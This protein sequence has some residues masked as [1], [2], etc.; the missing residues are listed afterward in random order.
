RGALVG[1]DAVTKSVIKLRKAFGD[2]AKEPSII[3]TIPKRGYRLVA[4]VRYLDADDDRR[5]TVPGL[6]EAESAPAE[7][8]GISLLSTQAPA[9]PRWRRA[10][11]AK[12]LLIMAALTVLAGFG[13]TLFLVWSTATL[14]APP[15]PVATAGRAPSIVVLPF[16]NLSDDPQFEAFADGISEDLITDLSG[17]PALLVIASNTSFTFKGK[18]IPA[19]E[20]A[21]DLNVDF[22]LEGNIRRQAGTVRLNAR[23]VDARNGLQRW[24]KRY[25]RQIADV[26][27]VQDELTRNIVDALAIKLSR[28]E[29]ERL[30]RRTTN[31]LAAYDAFQEGQRLAKIST[32]DSNREAQAMYRQAIELDPGYG[33]AYGALAYTLAFRYRRGWA[34][35]PQLTLERALEVARKAVDLD[36]SIPQTYWA[37]GFVHLMRKEYPLAEAAATQSITLTPN[38]AD[39]YGLLA[40]IKNALGEPESA[41]ALIKKGMQLNPY[42]TWDYPYNLGRAYYSLGRID[43][44][45]EAL[46]AAKT[47]NE[48]AVPIRLHLAASYV[49]A[50]RQD[51][52]EW[53]VQEVQMLSPTDTISHQKAAHPIQDEAL[54]NA[55]VEDLR[56]AGLSE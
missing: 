26:F 24:A 20:L 11:N 34:D 16:D 1:Y 48:N 53:E 37:L 31:N 46:E 23:L 50:G 7:R 42:Y 13:T 22:V 4:P 54:M 44:A 30:A 18:R 12:A 6:S 29:T 28:Q 32:P 45:I 55:F 56:A 41:I 43:E 49:R 47:R 38:Y 40:L 15:P 35:N 36:N 14:E 10:M 33:R 2:Q 9:A 5:S 21:A 25:D 52:A 27:A 8:T 51:D 39:G 3:E 17:L 19:R